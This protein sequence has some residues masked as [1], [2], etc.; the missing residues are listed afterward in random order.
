MMIVI[1][2]HMVDCRVCVLYVRSITHSVIVCMENR[3]MSE[4]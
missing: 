1:S 3:Y 2:E 4:T